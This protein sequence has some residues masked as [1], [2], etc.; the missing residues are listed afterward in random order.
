MLTCVPQ[1]QKKDG[2]CFCNCSV[3]LYCFIGELSQLILKDVND[4]W[5][6]ILVILLQLLMMH[7]SF[8][9]SNC[10]QKGGRFQPSSS[11]MSV[12]PRCAILSNGVLPSSSGGQTA[13]MPVVC[14]VL[15]ASACNEEVNPRH[16]DFRLITY[17]F[18]EQLYLPI[19]STYIQTLKIKFVFYQLIKY[20]I[21]LWPFFHTSLILVYTPTSQL[22]FPSD[23]KFLLFFF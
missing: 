20:Q 4:Q 22:H 15:E 16:W 17:C 2:S 19:P 7:S 1:M 21:S 13:S 11:S 10:N 14:T 8:W 18:R 12:Q 9:N 5:L 3:S 23:S 6:V